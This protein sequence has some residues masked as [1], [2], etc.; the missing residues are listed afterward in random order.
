MLSSFWHR[1]RLQILVIIVIGATPGLCWPES[2]NA[3]A[4]GS[5]A[6]RFKSIWNAAKLYQNP[7]NPVIQS[8]SLIGRYQGQYWSVDADQ[9][10]ADGW[11]NRRA[12]FGFQLSLDREF[13]ARRS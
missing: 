8:F 6:E 1:I 13:L 7:D 4:S 2:E 9:G 12:T 11:E 3:A 5:A 10:K